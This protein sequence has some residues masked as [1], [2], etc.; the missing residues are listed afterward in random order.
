[1]LNAIRD[2]FNPM[3]GD[4]VYA[5][6]MSDALNVY[7]PVRP[8]PLPDYWCNVGTDGRCVD[9]DNTDPVNHGDDDPDPWWRECLTIFCVRDVPDHPSLGPGHV[10][11]ANQPWGMLDYTQWYKF[12]WDGGGADWSRA[13]EIGGGHGEGAWC[14]LGGV[15]SGIFNYLI[16]LGPYNSRA[17]L[18]THMRKS[19]INIPDTRGRWRGP[20]YD[21]GSHGWEPAFRSCMETDMNTKDA[22]LRLVDQAAMLVSAQTSVHGYY[23]A[24]DRFWDRDLLFIGWGAADTGQNP[25]LADSDAR[26]CTAQCAADRVDDLDPNP[27]SRFTTTAAKAG[28]GTRQRFRAVLNELECFGGYRTRDGHFKLLFEDQ[29]GGQISYIFKGDAAQV[30]GV[31]YDVASPY[32]GGGSL[33]DPSSWPVQKVPSRHD[34][35]LGKTIS[36]IASSQRGGP[37]AACA[38]GHLLHT[39]QVSSTLMFT[40]GKITHS[41]GQWT[42][43]GVGTNFDATCVGRT[44]SFGG[45]TCTITAVASATS[46]TFDT[47]WMPTVTNRAYYLGRGPTPIPFTTRSPRAARCAAANSST[48]QPPR[49]SSTRSAASTASSAPPS[50]R[51][52]RPGTTATWFRAPG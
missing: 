14:G 36:R 25:S 50:A 29:A 35:M 27:G 21:Q 47:P 7:S 24:L 13:P 18:A 15:R 23:Y 41:S 42:A 44:I 52:A 20:P 6:M 10:H 39:P 40:P 16:W 31:A 12:M 1:M 22:T 30:H 33:N 9:Y 49:S 5:T 45:S 4:S 37:T 8:S 46:L 19:C 2:G 48:S 26:F 3:T 28:Q 38:N 32:G 11:Q 51:R 34:A 43:T 17:E